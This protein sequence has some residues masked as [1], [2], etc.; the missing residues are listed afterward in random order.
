MDKLYSMDDMREYADNFA[1]ARTEDIIYSLVVK[2]I[3]WRGLA[4]KF[5]L[6]DTNISAIEAAVMQNDANDLAVLVKLFRSGRPTLTESDREKLQSFQQRVHPWLIE[7]FGEKIANDKVERNWRFFEE[8]TETVQAADMT[9][10]E[11]HQLV[12]YVYNRPKG[13]LTQEV[14]GTM[15]TLAAL[16]LANGISMQES[17]ET[18]LARIL[19]PEIVL[20]IR[21]KQK[22]KPR[23]SPLPEH[24]PQ[25]N[26]QVRTRFSISR[27][28]MENVLK[29]GDEPGGLMAINPE[30]L[31]KLDEQRE[32]AMEMIE[33]ANVRVNEAIE[34]VLAY[35]RNMGVTEAEKA[36]LD[37]VSYFAKTWRKERD[38]QRIAMVPDTATTGVTLEVED[39]ET[40]LTL[41][42][43]KNV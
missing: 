42:G 35:I 25:T 17:A 21:E 39:L 34:P 20:K 27:E 33:H 36:A 28:W 2:I 15:V 32:A 40:V 24:A 31:K 12:D 18:E 8:A 30:W 9:R 7:C 4:R 19:R 41:Y 13:E 29:L 1:Q 23:F 37:R 11:A 14:G 43:A 10:E 6:R 16:C 38:A 26:P 22:G 3:E 5:I